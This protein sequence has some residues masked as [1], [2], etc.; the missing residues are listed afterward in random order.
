MTETRTLLGRSTLSFGHSCL[1]GISN[2]VLGI[3]GGLI[4]PH[5][6]LQLPLGLTPV[7]FVFTL[8]TSV[9]LPNLPRSLGNLFVGNGHR[10]GSSPAALLA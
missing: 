3:S 9:L 5:F 2:F 1:F 4:D 7:L 8:R 6:R 10:G